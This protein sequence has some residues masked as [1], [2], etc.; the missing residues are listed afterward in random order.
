MGM[1]TFE[2]ARVWRYMMN[3]IGKIIE[4]ASCKVDEEGL[5]LRAI[6]PSHVAMVDLYIPRAAF[7]EYQ[8]NGEETLS[9]TLDDINKVFRRAGRGD[10]LKLEWEDGKLTIILSGRVERQFTI[11]MPSVEAE[12]LPEPNLTF[13]VRARLLSKN[14]RESIKDV[15]PIADTVTF[16]SRGEEFIISGSSERGEATVALN[17]EGGALLELK[18]EE[19]CRSRY[20]I[21]YI[22][23]TL[24]VSQVADVAEVEFSSDM[25]C[26][27]RYEL[28]GGGEISFLIAPRVD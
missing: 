18:S 20:S 8:V 5:R 19:D 28:P 13:K 25:P 11:P 23:D 26:R 27:I 6:D 24:P 16:E 2:N 12:K 4:E 3:A 9:F 10:S 14:F 15:E 1:V 17:V 22:R 21:D 7:E